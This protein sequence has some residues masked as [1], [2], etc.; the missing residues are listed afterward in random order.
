[1]KGERLSDLGTGCV[2]LELETWIR[3]GIFL[4]LKDNF[5]YLFNEEL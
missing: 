3:C 2:E 5:L 1:M 4:K